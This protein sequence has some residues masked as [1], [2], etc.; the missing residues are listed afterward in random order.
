[1]EPSIMKH[2]P[3]SLW[4]FGPIGAGKSR[5]IAQLPLE[6]FERVDQDAE[7]EPILRAAKVPLDT[8]QHDESERAEFLRLRRWVSAELWEKVPAWRAEGRNLVFETTGDKPALF[9]AEVLAGRAAGY[10]TLA[11]ALRVPL[12]ECLKRNRGRE[13]VLADAIVENTWRDFEK[14]LTDG[15]YSEIFAQEQLHVCDSAQAAS[16]VA[17]AWIR[18]RLRNEES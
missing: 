8:R 4:I 11:C 18:E 7:L 6:S 1:M 3:L 15:V 13:R 9:R 17:N 5:T 2:R 10:E 12:A 14:A 16:R